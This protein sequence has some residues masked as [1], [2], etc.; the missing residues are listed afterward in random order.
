MKN[1]ISE[2]FKLILLLGL[3]VGCSAQVQEEPPQEPEKIEVAEQVEHSYVPLQQDDLFDLFCQS[4]FKT[5]CENNFLQTHNLFIH[6]SEYGIDLDEIKVSMGSLLPDPKEIEIDRSVL[7]GLQNFDYSSLSRENQQIYDQLTFQLE[8]DLK[9]NEERFNYLSSIWT[10]AV[11]LPQQI[12]QLFSLYTIYSE[13]DISYLIRLFESLEDLMEQARSY[14]AVQAELGYLSLDTT[15]QINYINQ[16]LSA[17]SN[18]PI[19]DHFAKNLEAFSLDDES[20]REYMEQI[21]EVINRYYYPAFEEMLSILNTY[22]SSNTGIRSMG[23]YPNGAD[24]YEVLM[25]I[26]SGSSFSLD[27]ME[28]DLQAQVNRYSV[29]RNELEARRPGIFNGIASISSGFSSIDDELVFLKNHYE[30]DFPEVDEIEVK[31]EAMSALEAR[32]VTTLAYMVTTPM[33]YHGAYQV[34]YN[35]NTSNFGSLD[36]FNTMAHESIPGHIYEEQYDKKYFDKNIE[37]I[38]YSFGFQ[39]GWATYAAN[40]SMS[41]TAI[42]PD[43]IEA[44]KINR[45]LSHLAVLQADMAIGRY[46]ISYSEA[47]ARYGLNTTTYNLL[48]QRPGLFFAYYYDSLILENLAYDAQEALGTDFEWLDFNTALLKAGS[49]NLHIISENVSDYIERNS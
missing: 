42:D 23:S 26:Q 48:C 21:D 39:E 30:T 35:P 8:N 28:A 27:E 3:T 10:N 38:L 2:I 22:G 13:L 33:D 17:R 49:V 32:D 20:F 45:A 5:I 47:R 24:Y 6:P 4:A 25:Q 9:A 1:K 36:F 14:T 44:F 11:G 7:N 15:Y 16:V 40:R 18:D 37:Y 41:W 46:G 19:H 12:E 29:M 31:V 34:F 43:Q